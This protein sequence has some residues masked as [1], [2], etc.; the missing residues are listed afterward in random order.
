MRTTLLLGTA[1][2]VLAAP[3]S[4]HERPPVHLARCRGS[5]P[6]FFFS[7]PFFSPPTTTFTSKGVKP[8]VGWWDASGGSVS[9]G[10]RGQGGPRAKSG[11][12]GSHG[13]DRRRGRLSMAATV[14]VASPAGAKGAF[15]L[16]ILLG[17][18]HR[19][20]RELGVRTSSAA[21]PSHPRAHGRG[22]GAGQTV[23]CGAAVG[24]R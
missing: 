6:S 14:P 10:R 1:A 22:R 17:V 13:R 19:R 4:V 21:R 20:A 5:A 8:Q 9:G 18:D 11:D 7:S 16:A 2:P 3:A 12:P 23:R 24:K 15:P